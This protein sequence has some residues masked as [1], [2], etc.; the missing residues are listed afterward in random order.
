MAKGYYERELDEAEAAF[1]GCDPL[2]AA[3]RAALSITPDMR[4]IEGTLLAQGF[5]VDI[6][7][8]AVFAPNGLDP[9]GLSES[10]D[11]L[12][13]IA[14]AKKGASL[15]GEWISFRDINAGDAHTFAFE[16]A[17]QPFLAKTF[18]GRLDRFLMAAKKL[19][20]SAAAFGDAAVRLDYFPLF[21]I[22]FVIWDADEEFP[23]SVN[24]LFDSRAE[25]CANPED[26]AVYSLHA[27]A[28]LAQAL[29]A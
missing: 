9:L 21:P 17:I 24:A 15:S 28:K 20:G 23:A 26:A 10:S 13:Y 4:R 14:H 16:H 19:G 3:S 8:A 5:S 29:E 12:R 22:A 2:E 25:A 27:A 11:I 6:A 7:T 18:S 1:F